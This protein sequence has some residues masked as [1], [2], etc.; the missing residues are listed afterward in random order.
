MTEEEWEQDRIKGEVLNRM[1][2]QTQSWEEA[3]AFPRQ[4]DMGRNRAK[5]SGIVSAPLRDEIAYSFPCHG[6][7]DMKLSDSAGLDPDQLSYFVTGAN[8]AQISVAFA[9]LMAAD[10]S[11]LSG[12]DWL[13]AVFRDRWIGFCGEA[14]TRKLIAVGADSPIMGLLRLGVVPEGGSSLQRSSFGNGSSVAISGGERLA[15]TGRW[16]RSGGSSCH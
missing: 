2:G 7:A 15:V 3:E 9:P 12:V 10:K 16:A 8:G 14:R 6:S 4:S 5:T 11:E 13:G 1:A